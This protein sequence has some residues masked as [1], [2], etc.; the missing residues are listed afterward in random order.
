MVGSNNERMFRARGMFECISSRAAAVVLLHMLLMP[1]GSA[2]VDED[3]T[4]AD[5]DSNAMNGSAV[6]H[7]VP[8]EPMPSETEPHA[9]SAV[10]DSLGGRIDSSL[11]REIRMEES[12]AL[13]LSGLIVDETQTKIGRDFYDYFYEIW[14]APA[15]AGDFMITIMEQPMP[16]LGT[17]I[18]VSVNDFEVFQSFV[19]PRGEVVEEAALS[20]AQRSYSFL[21]N[22]RQIIDQLEGDD[23]EGSGIY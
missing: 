16:R 10:G 9:E 13:E 11:Q 22:Y 20:A 12:L 14:R 17:R 1:C 15:Q 19:Q 7:A 4:R 2:Q 23:M 21:Q 3:R 5:A 18:T 8:G 6:H